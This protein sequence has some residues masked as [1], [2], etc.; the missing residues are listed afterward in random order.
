MLKFQRAQILFRMLLK[1][2][3]FAKTLGGQTGSSNRGIHTSW[4]QA[5]TYL[6]QRTSD[7]R[8]SIADV[9]DMCCQWLLHKV[10]FAHIPSLCCI[11]LA[12]MH[13]WPSLLQAHQC[14]SVK[15][16][17]CLSSLQYCIQ[18]GVL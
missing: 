3:Q 10:V 9:D 12:N 18:L 6:A 2:I 16:L 8:Q 17:W 13:Y 11:C 14:S 5:A 4:I 15:P 7:H 1:L